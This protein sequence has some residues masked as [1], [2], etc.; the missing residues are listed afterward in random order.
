[1]TRLIR[2]LAHARSQKSLT[3]TSWGALTVTQCDGRVW[4]TALLAWC[5]VGATVCTLL[6]AFETGPVA[7]PIA[8]KTFAS[9]SS[10]F[11][12][13]SPQAVR[14]QEQVP[15][16]ENNALAALSNPEEG[17]VPLVPSESE[18]EKASEGEG[19]NMGWVEVSRGARVHA[20]PSVSA[21][22]LRFYPV[23]TEL[24][25][26][27]YKQGWFRVSDPTTSEQGWIYEKY[28]ETNSVP[29][30]THIVS[31]PILQA[32][33]AGFEAAV[34]HPS[35]VRAKTQQ[36]KT[37][38]AQPVVHRKELFAGLLERAFSGY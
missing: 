2:E 38:P 6:M 1:M 17:R 20:G 26:M 21:S 22:T 37:E 33:K 14:A 35:M 25:F 28:I 30:Q 13:T 29:G 11:E 12:S 5:L 18:S 36:Q 27:D 16:T 3:G 31:Q 24:H 15:A 32:T 4:G 19:A 9:P 7:P 23:G 34:P 10:S 8:D